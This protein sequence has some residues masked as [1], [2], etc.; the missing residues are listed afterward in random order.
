[1]NI[2]ASCDEHRSLKSVSPE[3]L[4]SARRYNL[5]RFTLAFE[6]GSYES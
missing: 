3:I 6:K 4:E 1:M 5:A 2:I